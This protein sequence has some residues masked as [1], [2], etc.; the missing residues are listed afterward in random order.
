MEMTAQT[1]SPAIK[2]AASHS[3]VIP[4]RSQPLQTEFLRRAVKSIKA[5]TIYPTIVVKIIVA[6]DQ[7]QS[8]PAGLIDELELI[9]VISHAKSQA[10]ALNAGIRSAD[11]DCIAFL[12]DDDRWHPRFLEFAYKALA[13]AGFSSSTQLE[14][15]DK[16]AIVRIN[17]FPTPS[18]W[19]MPL[20]TLRTVGEFNENFRW[21]LDNEWLGR[22]T[23]NNIP[24]V[25]LAEATAPIDYGLMSQVRPWLANVIKVGGP[26]C[27]VVRHDEPFP[28]VRRMVHARSGLG[29]IR[30]SKEL[31]SESQREYQTIISQFGTIPW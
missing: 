29:Q 26:L 30:E 7:G 31:Q 3:V 15:D 11:T 12:E 22:L 2:T 25:H 27:R 16:E 17:D 9:E 21:H 20:T 28:L 14:V 13:S 1:A 19:L 4:S 18:G 24:R 10:A 23:K 6:V 8:L 5:Q